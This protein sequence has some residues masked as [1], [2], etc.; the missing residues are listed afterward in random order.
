MGERDAFVLKLES[1]GDVSWLKTY[2]GSDYD[3]SKSVKQ[4]SE[5]GYIIAGYSLS[6]GDDTDIWVVKLDS[7]GSVV[8]QKTYGDG[9]LEQAYSS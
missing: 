1:D 3:Y 9:S 5:G 6:F 8:W 7:E 4:T 2:G